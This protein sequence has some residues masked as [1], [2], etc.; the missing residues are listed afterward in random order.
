M[1]QTARELGFDGPYLT[2]LCEPELNIKYT[3]KYYGRLLRRYR[4]EVEWAISAYNLGSAR[5]TSA[6]RF[7]NQVYVNKVLH[8]KNKILLAKK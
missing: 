1:G 8:H 7:V 2:Q 6:G 3:V 4:G 5:K